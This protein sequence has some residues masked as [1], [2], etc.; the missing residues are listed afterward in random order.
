MH[1]RTFL[2]TAAFAMVLGLAIVAAGPSEACTTPPVVPPEVVVE[3]HEVCFP[4][5][6][7]T[8]CMVRAW[9]TLLNYST[10][11]EAEG[12]FCACGLDDVGPIKEVLYARLCDEDGNKLAQFFF[13]QDD[14]ATAAITKFT[15]GTAQGFVAELVGDVPGGQTVDLK[16]EVLLEG[17]TWIDGEDVADD[18]LS[19]TSPAVVTGGWN[20]A[21]GELTGAHDGFVPPEG[22]YDCFPN[23]CPCFQTRNSNTVYLNGAEKT[24]ARRGLIDLADLKACRK[25]IGIG[26]D[27]IGTLP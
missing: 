21:T 23:G 7:P 18:I 2:T 15:N 20:P 10:F 12:Q 14:D 25:V 9:I 8:H 6:H 24:L 11:A 16:F 3:L 4:I 26:D 19:G 17:G 13:E 5:D 22:G 1:K 27:T